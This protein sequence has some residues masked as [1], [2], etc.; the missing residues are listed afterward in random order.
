MWPLSTEVQ[1][2]SSIVV[3]LL[4]DCQ[5]AYLSVEERDERTE[6]ILEIVAVLAKMITGKQMIRSVA[7]RI[8]LLGSHLDGDE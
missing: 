2:L 6:P 3:Q 1:L 8:T 4:S 5:E 7:L